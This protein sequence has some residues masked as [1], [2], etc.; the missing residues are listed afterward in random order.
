ML[1]DRQ[2]DNLIQPIIN[3]QHKIE[4]FVLGK[5]ADRINEIG[6]LVPSDIKMLEQLYK[7]GADVRVINRELVRQTQLQERRIK[8]L[9]RYVAQDNYKDAQPFYNY[10]RRRYIPFSQNESL[11]RVVDAVE[12]VTLGTYKN[13]SQSTAI[14]VAW[15]DAITGVIVEYLSIEDA[16]KKVVDT[17]IQAVQSGIVDYNTAMKNVIS[18]LSD[19]GLNTVVYKSGSGR[20]IHQRLDSAVRRNLLD[21]I[22]AVNQA[23]QNEIGKQV[24]A[25]GVEL[26]VHAMSA[27]DHEPIQ[28]HQFTMEE[29]DKCQTQQDFYDVNGTHFSGMERP[30]GVWNC[31]HFAYNIIIGVQKP[32]YTLQ[33]LE[34]FKANNAKGYDYKDSKGHKK[35]LSMYECT[36][37]QRQYELSIRKAREAKQLAEQ[38]G[39]LEVAQ[40]YQLRINQRLAEYTRFSKDCGLKPQYIRTK[41]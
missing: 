21:G 13:I 27:P 30:I 2:I 37:K 25:D 38:A 34:E 9:I 6:T 18:T 19:S 11:Q 20:I 24:G 29:Y 22:R 1:T 14:S 35:H 40:K 32:R 33:Q 7:S 15:K 16:Y 3:R 41:V 8:K 12:S 31:R 23:V 4:M 39:M 36:Q 10:R 5:M 26:S 28:G 17:G